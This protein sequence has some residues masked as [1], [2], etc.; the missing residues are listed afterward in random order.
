MYDALSV[1]ITTEGEISNCV[2]SWLLAKGK[3]S[4]LQHPCI[5]IRYLIIALSS[6]RNK[7]KITYLQ[8]T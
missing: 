5:A 1:Q 4:Q 2:G 8:K 6:K 3:P 7:K